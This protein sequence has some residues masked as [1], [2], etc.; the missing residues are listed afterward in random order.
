MSKKYSAI[1]PLLTY[2]GSKDNQSQLL[3]DRMPPVAFESRVETFAGG[4]GIERNLPRAKI[5]AIVN[6][7]DPDVI[8]TYVAAVG[9]PDEVMTVL[10]T[11]RPCR[12]TF[13]RLRDSRNTP[14]WWDQSDAERAAAMIYLAK[15]SVNSCMKSFSVSSKSRSNFNPNMDLR[16]FRDR[17]EGVL[18]ENL[19]WRDLFEPLI[20]KPRE[21]CLFLYQDAPYVVADSQ[22]Y[23]RFNFDSTQHIALA[24]S[25][26]RVNALNDGE[27]RR[28]Y[29]MLSYDDDP[30][31]F[32]RSLYRPEFGF[33][34]ETI[35]THYASEHHA[36]RCRNELVITNYNTKTFEFLPLGDDGDTDS[37]ASPLPRPDR[38]D[39]DTAA[40]VPRSGDT[41]D[42]E[43][44]TVRGT[45]VTTDPSPGGLGQGGIS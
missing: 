1:K 34:I 8:G 19:Y 31:G 9:R 4:L 21:V 25:V 2:I 41:R 33:T 38:R 30:A 23:Y 40:R 20:F 24:R 10:R 11:M 7:I 22:K 35:Q 39:G 42:I 3:R 44:T 12:V 27:R 26:A 17:F 6:D 18:F 43:C 14:A 36:D 32:I 15:N 37:T 5:Q 13:N 29:L 28:V 16:P 45:S